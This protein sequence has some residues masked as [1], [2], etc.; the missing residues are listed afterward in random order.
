M[1]DNPYVRLTSL[2]LDWYSLSAFYSV[3]LYLHLVFDSKN[4]NSDNCRLQN[5]AVC[6]AKMSLCICLYR[7]YR[8]HHFGVLL[9]GS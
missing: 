8:Q 9:N 6:I 3:I 7:A 2:Y 4:K 5:S 1:L